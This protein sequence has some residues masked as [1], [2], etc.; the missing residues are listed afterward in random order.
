[1]NGNIKELSEISNKLN[2]LL[3]KLYEDDTQN[4]DDNDDQQQTDDTAATNTDEQENTVAEPVNDDVGSDEQVELNA[5]RQQDGS[6]PSTMPSTVSAPYGTTSTN[7][8]GSGNPLEL[9][10]GTDTDVAQDTSEQYDAINPDGKATISF[11]RGNWN[12]FTSIPQKTNE[13]IM[14]IQKTIIPLIEVGL[15]ELLGNNKAFVGQDF[16]ST[17]TM[18]DNNPTI[19]CQLTYRVELFIG[20][21]ISQE[22]IAHDAKYLLDRVKVVP[23]VQWNHCSIDCTEGLVKLDFII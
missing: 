4:K 10:D 7:I 2:S 16:N 6:S 8:D 23:N 19:E 15:I 11:E 18:N 20:T 13:K 21:D 3:F 14:T 9:A 22:D 12:N 5:Q 1:M 17:F